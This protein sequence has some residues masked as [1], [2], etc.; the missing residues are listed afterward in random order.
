MEPIAYRFE[1]FILQPDDRLLTQNDV[2]VDLNSRYLDALALLVREPGRLVTKTRFMDEVWKGVPVTDEALTQ[3]VRTLRRRLG[4][5]A[6]HPR[7]IETVPGHGYRFIASVEP[8]TGFDAAT[9]A[10]DASVPTPGWSWPTIM[11]RG[12]AAT[13]GGGGAGAIGGLAYAMIGSAPTVSVQMG[14]ASVL[15]VLTGLTMVVGL[16]GGAGV[17]FGIAIA[18]FVPGRRWQWSLVGGATG[19]MLVGGLV[20]M[21]G[22]DAFNLLLGHS[23]GDVTGAVEGI[24][25]GSAVGLGHGLAC[26]LAAKGALRA[27]IVVAALLTGSAGAAIPWMG[28]RLMGGSLD[29]LT[30]GFPDSRFRLET[31]GGFFG[32]VGFGPVAQS[33]TGG[34]EGAL[35]GAC[36][37]G[38]MILA[39]QHDGG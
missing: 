10:P 12:T 33:V 3:C 9:L 36:V 20:E 39:G 38:A 11:R 2:P 15:L 6:A 31:L 22:V 8:V 35:F 19:G 13:L 1:D 5:D 26:R 7:F 25:L 34:M 29:G 28:G 32:D 27:G 14:T 21:V 18:G 4:D 17:G 23:P 24:V 16:L 30:R 37:V